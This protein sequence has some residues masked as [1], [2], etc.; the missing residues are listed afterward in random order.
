MIDRLIVFLIMLL[1]TISIGGLIYGLYWVS[2]LDDYD[3]D[4]KGDDNENKQ[5]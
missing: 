3:K 1:L 5:S 4:E 2:R